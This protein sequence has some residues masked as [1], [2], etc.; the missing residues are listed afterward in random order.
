MRCNLYREEVVQGGGE[1]SW[2]IVLV[3]GL[4][5]GATASHRIGSSFDALSD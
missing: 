2:L 4:Q 5:Q 3:E 1:R